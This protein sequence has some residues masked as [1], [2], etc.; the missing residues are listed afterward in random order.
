MKKIC[1]KFNKKLNNIIFNL[2]YIILMDYL[3]ESRNNILM[4]KQLLNKIK[5]YDLPKL[6]D[7]NEK[8][9]YSKG[10]FISLP[11]YHY[12]SELKAY[13][14]FAS[15]VSDF[16]MLKK[17][18]FGIPDNK[19]III[20]PIDIYKT[21]IKWVENNINDVVQEALYITDYDIRIFDLLNFKVNKTIITINFTS[22]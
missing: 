16:G 4:A 7:N 8:L 13:E 21:E 6:P 10:G 14:S 18:M 1:K 15:G 2:N 20:T 12:L 5:Y 9:P 11:L 22:T 3:I 17:S 19:F